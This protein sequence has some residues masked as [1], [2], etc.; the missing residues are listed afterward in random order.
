W[1]I[2]R[3]EI[4]QAMSL[5]NK[6]IT[7]YGGMR[8]GL[9]LANPEQSQVPM[10]RG[11]IQQ[12]YGNWQGTEQTLNLIINGAFEGRSGDDMNFSF[13]WRANTPLDDM[14]K[15]AMAAAMPQVNV[16]TLISPDVKF[17]YDQAGYHGALADFG[18]FLK[19][20]TNT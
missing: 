10:V 1:G 8:K 4:S 19:Q 18:Q 2:S 15:T 7:V 6:W 9:P 12:A 5:T 17:D 20:V 3:E 11:Y 13:L 14:L 16:E